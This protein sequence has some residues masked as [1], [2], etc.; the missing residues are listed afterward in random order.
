[1]YGDLQMTNGTYKFKCSGKVFRFKAHPN[2]CAHDFIVG[3]AG[4]ADD[5]LEVKYFF[6]DPDK[7]PPVAKGVYG[8][9]LTERGEIYRFDNYKRWIETNEP[10]SAIGS[11]R[12]FALGAMA[13][14]LSPKEAVKVAMTKDTFTGMGIKGYHI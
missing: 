4:T 13:A 1:M 7:K 5:M 10:F 3:F 11:G 6:D 14:G 2:T 8:L 12:D 9:V